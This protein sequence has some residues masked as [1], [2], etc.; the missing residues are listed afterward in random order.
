MEYP[1]LAKYKGSVS[2]G[3][4]QQIIDWVQGIPPMPAVAARALRLI[5]DPNCTAAEVANVLLHDAALAA[6]I[7]RAGNSAAAARSEHVDTLQE[8]V[9]VVGFR[10]VKGV[11]MA[12]VMR[13]WNPNFTPMVRAVWER[14]IGT[15]VATRVLR[16][17]LGRGDTERFFL[18][19]LLHNLGQVVMLSNPEIGRAFPRVLKLIAERSFTFSGAET[20]V[21]GFSHPIVG[22]LVAQKWGFPLDLCRSILQYDDP[23]DPGDDEGA[24]V[25]LKLAS[26]VSLSA[27]IG[28]VACY[29]LNPGDMQNLAVQLGFPK[30]RL[31][32]ELKRVEELTKSQFLAESSLYS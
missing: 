24:S 27:N 23:I 12:S 9:Q 18:A 3:H 4:V 16:S 15:A 29:P 22:A 11:V 2:Q 17:R 19:G 30:G 6:Q 10:Y 14:S 1:L 21:I 28:A 32:V 5:D 26:L 13:R 25:T 20:E 7:L 31:D 8:A